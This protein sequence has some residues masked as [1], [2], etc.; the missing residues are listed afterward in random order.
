MQPREKRRL[1]ADLEAGRQ[2]LLA[3]LANV[4]EDLATRAPGPGKWSILECI[5]HL[6]VSEDALL[7]MI[8]AAQRADAP[9]GSAERE[10]RIVAVG[11]NRAQPF[12]S[13][14]VGRPTGRY[15]TLDEALGHFLNARE[16]TTHLIENCSEDLRVRLTTHP[17]A[18]KVNCYEILLMIAVHPRRHAEQI[19]EIK[20][21]LA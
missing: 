15:R 3:V 8:S 17:L 11:L 2:V 16:Q 21:A 9:V 6:A 5:E 13:P 4:S 18:G 19:A 14:E 20:S 7:A 1:L 12:A 10:V